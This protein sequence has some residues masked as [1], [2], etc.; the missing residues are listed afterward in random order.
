M[1][2]IVQGMQLFSFFYMFYC[3]NPNLW[4]RAIY[5]YYA[6]FLIPIKRV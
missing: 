1:A 4:A 6:D 2:G 3:K 5:Q